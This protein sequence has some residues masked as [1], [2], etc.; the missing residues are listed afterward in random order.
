MLQVTGFQVRLVAEFTQID[1]IH[2]TENIFPDLL[3]I[4]MDG[5]RL[6][7]RTEI[8][9]QSAARKYLI[10]VNGFYDI[11][12]GDCRIIFIQVKSA[13]WTFQG[14]HEAPAAQ[15]LKNLGDEI[16]RRVDP[17]CDLLDADLLSFR[18]FAGYVDHS[19]D[20]VLTGL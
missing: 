19:P 2:H 15:L 6:G 4:V 10:P 1:A 9:A 3:E 5:T 8:K 14:L 13:I 18:G 17:L 16:F 20:A 7:F 11:G 12:Q